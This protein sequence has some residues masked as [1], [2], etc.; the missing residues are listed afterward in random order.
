[1]KR[2]CRALL[3]AYITLIVLMAAVMLD[4]ALAH[5]DRICIRHLPGGRCLQCMG[6]G[7]GDQGSLHTICRVVDDDP[8]PELPRLIQA[9]GG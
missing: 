6:I 4:T 7:G 2:H 9:P 5:A 3:T 1:M 8:T